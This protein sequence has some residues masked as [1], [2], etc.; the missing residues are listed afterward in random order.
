MYTGKQVIL[1]SQD[2]TLAAVAMGPTVAQFYTGNN[3]NL[4]V[5]GLAMLLRKFWSNR[6]EPSLQ[7]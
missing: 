3:S 6:V 2:A 1:L 4:R 7:V 5:P